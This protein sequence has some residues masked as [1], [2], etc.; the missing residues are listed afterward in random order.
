MEKRSHKG[1]ATPKKASISSSHS[2][3]LQS[4]YFP[5]ATRKLHIRAGPI[6]VNERKFAKYSGLFLWQNGTVLNSA[7]LPFAV[8]F[9][10]GM[11]TSRLHTMRHVPEPF[12]PKR[13]SG[14]TSYFS[15]AESFIKKNK[16]ATLN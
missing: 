7:T 5:K 1:G 15:M 4:Y 13:T 3:Q 10:M 14:S 12:S 16:V 6:K 9:L 8:V 2:S 11:T